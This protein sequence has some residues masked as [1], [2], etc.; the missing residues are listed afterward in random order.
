MKAEKVE[1]SLTPSVISDGSVKDDD[2]LG[3]ATSE[4]KTDGEGAAG[5]SSNTLQGAS[6][7]LVGLQLVGTSAIHPAAL[8]LLVSCGRCKSPLDMKLSTPKDGTVLEV[9]GTFYSS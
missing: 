2:T 8:K 6:L 5:A 3:G 1:K 4:G 7:A 9:T